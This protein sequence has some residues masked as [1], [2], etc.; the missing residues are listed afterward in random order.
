MVLEVAEF[1]PENFA[2]IPLVTPRNGTYEFTTQ[3]PAPM[4]LRKLHLGD[5]KRACEEHAGSM[6]LKLND[7]APNKNNEIDNI[8]Y[9]LLRAISKYH[10]IQSPS[11]NVCITPSVKHLVKANLLQERTSQKGFDAVF[12]ILLHWKKNNICW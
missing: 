2:A 12:N 4:A 9:R 6:I 10:A 5:L 3:H 11:S 7:F 1:R 8:P